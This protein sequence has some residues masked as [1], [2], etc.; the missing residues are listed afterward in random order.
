MKTQPDVIGAASLGID[1]SQ[2]KLHLA[3]PHKFLGKFNNI[4]ASHQQLIK[5]VLAQQPT[6][7]VFEASGGY[8]RAICDALQ[9]AGV[10][11]SVAQPG[12]VRHFARSL[13]VLAKT[14]VIDAQLIARFDTATQPG[15][16]PKTPKNHLHFR[17]LVDRRGQVIEDRVRETNRL[18]TCADAPMR[19]CIEAHITSLR[20]QEQTLDQQIAAVIKADAELNQKGEVMS[21]QTG[22]GPQTI[23]TLF[24][25]L[26][27][28]GSLDRQQVAAIAG[29]APHPRESGTWK[30]QRRISGGRAPV[31]KAMSCSGAQ[32][33]VH[34]RPF[35]SPM[36]PGH[37][38]V[39]RSSDRQRQVL[40]TS[41]HRLRP[42]DA[43][44]PE[45]PPEKETTQIPWPQRDTS[46]LT[47]DTVA[48]R[49]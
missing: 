23:C 8:E 21:Q 9:D 43:H 5:R 44:P 6:G 26:P 33:D 28:L 1:V 2:S 3:A 20:E 11:V 31:R 45:H 34:G 16:T 13:N 47:S 40:Q 7:L 48:S 41:H 35:S 32:R 17:A 39:S 25:H 38:P 19:A 15:P 30:G 36:V 14:D 49:E 10:P 37:P 24:A 27:E 46:N 18:E 22:V 29:V 4:L 42:Q 12:C